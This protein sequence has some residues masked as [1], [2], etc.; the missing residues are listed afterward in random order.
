MLISVEI[1]GI[2][3]PLRR[4]KC[5][6]RSL[7][8]TTIIT[9]MVVCLQ[10]S[11]PWI[12]ALPNPLT[13]PPPAPIRPPLTT[14]PPTTT[15]P[16]TIPPTTTPPTTTPPTTTP[17]PKTTTPPTTTTPPPKTTTPPTTTTPPPKTTTPP[18]KPPPT[19]INR[20]KVWKKPPPP[21]PTKEEIRKKRLTLAALAAFNAALFVANPTP[22]NAMSFVN[23]AMQS[24]MKGGDMPFGV[25]PGDAAAFLLMNPD[26]VK[27]WLKGEKPLST[28]GTNPWDPESLYP[29]DMAASIRKTKEEAAKLEEEWAKQ[30]RDA[31]SRRE[32]RRKQL[33][34]IF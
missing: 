13:P 4:L 27:R 25:T 26:V 34:K 20:P 31:L 22:A 23:S 24:G 28:V 15:P 21:P 10:P 2:E 12:G 33:R 32:K 9:G 1:F 30:E 7:Q 14:I 19:V 6:Q 3:L 18:P 16:T 29:P 5:F 8:K 17:P 11:A